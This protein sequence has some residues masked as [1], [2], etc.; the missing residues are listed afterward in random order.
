MST[1][2]FYIP[3]RYR[4]STGALLKAA[5]EKTKGP[6][7][8][9]ILYVAP[10]PAKV[11]DAQ[12]TLQRITGGCYIPPEMMTIK[13]VSKRLYSLRGDRNVISHHLIPVII[14]HISGKGIG[15][16][17]LITDFINE[18]KQYHPGKEIGTVEKELRAIFYE[19]GIPEEVSNRAIEAIEIFKTYQE[20]LERQSVA[21]EDDVM[22]I[23]PRLIREHN[24]SIET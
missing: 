11:R 4:G 13:Q 22:S 14:S 23:C 17:S 15:F 19:L 18:I 9:R 5:V 6:D 24:W 7:Y 16:A 3:F 1:K 8:S 21:D 10:T 12:Q 2:V 20:I